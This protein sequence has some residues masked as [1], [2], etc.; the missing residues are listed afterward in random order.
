V[1]QGPRIL[2]P[3]LFV[4]CVAI[5]CVA[6]IHPLSSASDFRPYYR[7]A[8]HIV[9]GESPYLGDGY[10]YPP[11]LAF[12][13]APLALLD[14]ARA[15]LC[16]F[17]LSQFFL[18]ASAVLLWRRFGRDWP[19]ACWIALVWAA[20]GAADESL[21]RGQVGPL[22]TLLVVLAMTGRSAAIGVGFAIKLFPGL[23]GVAVLLRRERRAIVTMLLWGVA[24]LLVPW[25]AVAALFRGPAGV[26]TG[27]TWTGTPALLSWSLP[28]VVLRVLD[29]TA[30]EQGMDLYRFRLPFEQSAISLAVAALT[31]AVGLTVLVRSK[32]QFPW[33][34]AALV[35]LALA[36]T[37][38]GWFNRQLRFVD[39]FVPM[40]IELPRRDLCGEVLASR[41]LH[42][43]EP[44]NTPHGDVPGDLAYGS[45]R[46]RGLPSQLVSREWFNRVHQTDLIPAPTI[47]NTGQPPRIPTFHGLAA[48]N[49]V[50]HESVTARQKSWLRD[51]GIAH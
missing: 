40:R 27:G 35:A 14:F 32:V 36:A 5:Y 6:T 25:L 28:S 2:G 29:P 44:V 23:L 50:V 47:K 18:I 49:T 15:Q 12:L 4:L 38:I 26:S 30:W 13:L 7:A 39:I 42:S 16:W 46:L 17:V 1:R 22:L 9:H 48:Q 19:S 34:I 8:Q 10:I 20:G 51:M 37:P 3:L 45:H 31:L 41:R 24:T 43:Q 33:M 21:T 11:L